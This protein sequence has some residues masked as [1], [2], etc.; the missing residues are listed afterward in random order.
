MI[1]IDLL[2]HAHLGTA[3]DAHI[4]PD[5]AEGLGQSER[6]T[7]VQHPGGL[8]GVRIDR[9]GGA[10]VVVADFRVANTQMLG[11]GIA[12][13]F[14]DLRQGVLRYPDAHRVSLP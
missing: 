4:G 5:T 3:V 6:G 14:L 11:E 9:H 7:A 13:L 10:Q 8:P 1:G 2:P 12:R